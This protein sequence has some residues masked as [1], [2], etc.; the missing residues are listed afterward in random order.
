LFGIFAWGS[1][2]YRRRGMIG[3][4]SAPLLSAAGLFVM[5]MI[6]LRYEVGGD[7]GN[8][9]RI[10]EDISYVDFTDALLMSDPGY[11][12]LNW[13]AA[14]VG[15][16]MWLVNLGSAL[17]FTWGLV[18]F[19]KQQ[20]NPWLAVLVAVPYLI[21]VVAMGYTRQAVAMGLILAGLSVLDRSS[22]LRF[23][24]YI[25]L[26]AAFHK[27]AIVVLPLVAL[28][29]TRQRIVTIGV[30]L[31][32]GVLLYYVFVQASIDRMMANYVGAEYSS[33]GAYIRVMMNLPPALLFLLFQK[34]FQL[35]E[36]PRK[37]WRNFSIAS[38]MSMVLLGVVASTTAVDRISLYLIP[39]QMFV[40][41][42]LPEAF[43]D[44]RRANIQI[45]LL[46]IAYSALVQFVW[47]N[48]ADHAYA[49]LPYQLYPLTD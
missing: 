22:V 8:Y 15:A 30:L 29:T 36:Q 48:F 40:L 4:G 35:Q 26:A 39:L 37:L 44:R 21:I 16:G 3:S 12:L 24:G 45:V 28:A 32:T 41:S 9:L 1:V 2:E 19:A 13:G 5:L 23:T 6:G 25:L 20:P 18:K 10:Y 42:R 27:S 38:I 49:W 7:W 43:P 33:Q 46:I 47:L 31:V 11:A 14:R 34:R 17:I